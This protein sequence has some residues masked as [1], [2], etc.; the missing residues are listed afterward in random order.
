MFLTTVF[1][2]LTRFDMMATVEIQVTLDGS[3]DRR[4]DC[5]RCMEKWAWWIG[6]KQISSFLA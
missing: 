1:W 2:I 4:L 5:T 6:D 3:R